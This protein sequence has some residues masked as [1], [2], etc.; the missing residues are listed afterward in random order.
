[1]LG[2]RFEMRD[3]GGGGGDADG[4]GGASGTPDRRREE[5]EEGERERERAAEREFD[6][7]LAG[8][9]KA[10]ENSGYLAVD[11]QVRLVY[12]FGFYLVL[13]SFGLVSGLAL[14]WLWSLV[15]V[16]L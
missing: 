10:A 11:A 13:V 15:L 12:L 3:M 16:W 7:S 6:F 5:D 14:V 8:V 9:L 4:E 2:V 1:M